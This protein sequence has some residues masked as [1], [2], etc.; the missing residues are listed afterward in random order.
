MEVKSK[1]FQKIHSTLVSSC[2]TLLP[3]HLQLQEQFEE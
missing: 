3:Q 2:H 1:D